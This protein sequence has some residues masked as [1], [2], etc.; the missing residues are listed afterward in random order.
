MVSMVRLRERVERYLVQR[1]DIEQEERAV[2]VYGGVAHGWRVVARNVRCRVLLERRTG[3]QALEIGSQE[4]IREQYRLVV[5]VG[6]VLVADMRVRVG[7][8]VYHVVA[9]QAG[10]SEALD[11]QATLVRMRE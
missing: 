3:S 9:V 5:P 1:C 8:D 11:V 7:S 10:Q 2:D 4:S 6:T